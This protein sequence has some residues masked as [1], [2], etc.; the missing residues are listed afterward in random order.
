VES[1]LHIGLSNA[2]AAAVLALV[3]GAA[4]RLC[5][6]RPA[7]VHGLWLLVLVKLVT[8]PLVDVRVPWPAAPATPPA[9]TPPRPE[10]GELPPAGP[11]AVEE[12]AGAGGKVE[13]E[14]VAIPV[15]VIAPEAPAAAAPEPSPWTWDRVLCSAWLAG[16]LGWFVLAGM[17]M[18]CFLRLLRHGRPAPAALRERASALARTLGLRRCPEVLLLPGRLAP[19]LWAFA[20]RPRLCL[21]T[22]LLESVDGAALD[23]LLVHELAHLR[24]R[25]HWV[26]RLEFVV[27]GL[28]WWHPVA[29]YARRE[30]REAE[31]QCCDAWVV[32]AL[33]G[34]GR[35]YAAALVD[36][37]DFLSTDAPAVPLAASGIGQVADLKRRLTMILRGTTPYRLGWGGLLAV[38]G[39]GALL[40]LWPHLAQAEP[41]REEEEDPP[42][43]RTES[44]EVRKA[45]EE[46]EALK[47][48]VRAAE[49]QVQAAT[50]QAEVVKA[51]AEARR[52]QL[53]RAMEQL[54]LT[55]RKHLEEERAR[56]IQPQARRQEA[57]GI[58]IRV[59]VVG[60]ENADEVKKL[61]GKI[62]DAV[63]GK[64]RIEVSVSPQG[65]STYPPPAGNKP[66]NAVAPGAAVGAPQ[67]PSPQPGAPDLPPPPKSLERK[68][69]ELQRELEELRREIRHPRPRAPVLPTPPGR[70]APVPPVPDPPEPLGP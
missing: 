13:Q 64:A 19:L 14:A 70:P 57:K 65:G 9:D 12:I 18:A 16:S 34:S 58:V 44:P 63:G 36:A 41:A 6:R 4:G 2:V 69:E 7:V 28:Y 37:L 55:Q 60:T 29:W 5:R 43:A 35:T 22:G 21:P 10:V 20:G 40:P 45:K 27:L 26:R 39:L 53:Q 51:E 23:T 42:P 3:A 1:L 25:D 33:P 59:Q 66:P 11:P 56:K 38:L 48:A 24:R 54:H 15:A 31:E 62:A 32:A 49:A 50:A 30:L 61:V 8:P 46:L 68:V 67:I 47:A 17:R 52:A